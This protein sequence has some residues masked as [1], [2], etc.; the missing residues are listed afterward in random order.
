MPEFAQQPLE[1][2]GKGRRRFYFHTSIHIEDS[3]EIHNIDINSDYCSGEEKYDG[4]KI[5]I[6]SRKLI[7][8]SGGMPWGG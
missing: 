4:K 5:V 7:T 6:I 1:P 8:F 3:T 2:A